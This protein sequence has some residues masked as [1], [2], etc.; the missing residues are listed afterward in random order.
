MKILP[1]SA[2]IQGGLAQMA[3]VRLGCFAGGSTIS[4]MGVEVAEEGEARATPETTVA[5]AVLLFL[6]SLQACCLFLSRPFFRTH[7]SSIWVLESL[8]LKPW[9]WLG[10]T[11]MLFPP[12]QM[13]S[14]VPILLNTLAP[15]TAARPLT[16]LR[17]WVKG[18]ERL[19]GCRGVLVA[20]RF[21]PVSLLGSAD[22]PPLFSTRPLCGDL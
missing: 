7:S 18:G 22:C 15:Y 20:R 5:T 4:E 3:A 6:L 12:L 13:R 1:P 14:P 10:D 16:G 19:L 11:R 9:R 17:S 8:Q 2:F 21:L